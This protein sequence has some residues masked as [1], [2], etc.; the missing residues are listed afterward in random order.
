MGRIRTIKPEFP[1]SE[2]VGRLSREARLLFLLL[3]TVVDD[4]GRC[5]GSSRI[6]ASL[7][8]PYDDDAKTLIDGW[9]SELD[10]NSM[11][12]RYVHEDQTYI[13]VINFNKHQKIDHPTESKFPS[14]DESSRILA[15]P[16]EKERG[17]KEGIKDQGGLASESSRVPDWL[18]VELWNSFV[19]MRKKIKKPLTEHAKKL[20]I[21]KLE[22]FRAKGY[23][24]SGILSDSILN[25]WQGLYEPKEKPA[26]KWVAGD[27]TNPDDWTAARLP[28]E[29]L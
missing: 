26:K 22:G 5:R 14:F 12:R 8:Y 17:I 11:A 10:K 21:N 13:E 15:N 20:A 6:L 1:Q 27:P 23:D 2:S 16:R 7:L 19:E 3:F 4:S 18:P 24:V 25:D 29:A 9:I 28:V